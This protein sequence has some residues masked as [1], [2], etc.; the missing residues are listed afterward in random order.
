M[1]ASMFSGRYEAQLDRDELGNVFFDYS[2]SIMMPL[3]EF[4]R[5]TRDMGGAEQVPLPEIE[6]E[7]QAAWMAM[8]TFL[9]L[10]DTLYP[11]TVLRGIHLDVKIADLQGWTMFFSRPPSHR[12]RVEDF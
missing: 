2:A 11:T 9:G 7:R 1:L 3:I 8:L 5:L 10:K 6:I 12:S 4:L